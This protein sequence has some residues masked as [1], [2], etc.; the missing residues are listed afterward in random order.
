MFGPSDDASVHSAQSMAWKIKQNSN[1]ELRQKFVDQTV[2]QAK[3]LGLT[4]PDPDLRWNEQKG[5]HDFGEPDWEEFF[6]VIAGNGPCN[7]E[8]L[9]ARKKAWSDGAWFRDGL[10]AHAEKAADRRAA[11]KI[12]AE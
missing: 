9:D 11:A 12:A 7:A 5:G 4:V 1:D 6:N 10:T 2:P 8:R 3:Y